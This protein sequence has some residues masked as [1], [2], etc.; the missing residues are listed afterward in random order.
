VAGR[1][2]RGLLGGR[3]VLQTFQPDHYAIRAASNHDYQTFYRRELALRQDLRYPP[4]ARLVRIIYRSPKNAEAEEN[5]NQLAIQL[6]NA[7][8]DAG[9]KIDIIGPAPCYFERI[10]GFY[11]WHIVLRGSDPAQILPSTLPEGWGI[12]IDPVSLL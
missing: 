3:V 10:R 8:H 4:Y 1:A 7:I 5:A 11:R 6:Q 12:D 2:G 9:L